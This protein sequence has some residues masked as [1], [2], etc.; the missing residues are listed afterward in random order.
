L[1]IWVGAAD[2]SSGE[3][4]TFGDLVSLYGDFRRI[5]TCDAK[6]ANS[7]C[8]LT[9]PPKPLPG[10]Y[11]PAKFTKQR[12]KAMKDLA[13]GWNFWDANLITSQAS[14]VLVTNR[15]V[16]EGKNH[17]G[18]W[19]DEFYKIAKGNHWHFSPTALKWYVAM[20]RQ[21][22][23][24]MSKAARAKNAEERQ[25]LIWK[26]MHYE[27]HALHSLTDLFA[28]GHV[29]VDRYVTTDTMLA[30]NKQ[31]KAPFPS[32]QANIWRTTFSSP[33]PNG[34]LLKKPK[35]QAVSKVSE[36]DLNVITGP[37]SLIMRNARYESQ[38]HTNS[39]QLEAKYEISK[40]A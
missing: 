28:P 38:F 4:F 12:Y 36:I 11:N 23:Y 39:M 21:A 2:R 22:F 8:R 3:W 6:A 9:N 24:M 14:S 16:I 33:E 31:Q 10:N 13:Q 37:T 17:Q 27:G 18:A 5:I 29:M 40:A 26:A 35:F 30:G 34:K 25:R 20:H 7:D 15:G 32:W 1:L 19:S